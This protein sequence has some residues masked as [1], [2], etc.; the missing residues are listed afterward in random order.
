MHGAL[1]LAIPLRFGQSLEVLPGKQGVLTW[2]SMDISGVWFSGKYEIPSL[3]IIE[4]SDEEKALILR[5]ILRSA[6][7][8]SRGKIE[9][10]GGADILTQANFN[11][12]WGLG[13]SSTLIFNLASWLGISATTCFGKISK[14]PGMTLRVPVSR[15]RSFIS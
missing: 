14:P 12:H 10:F 7:N 9:K 15:A 13:T 8:L 4:S 2:E 3:E 6:E 11:R 5:D 1:A